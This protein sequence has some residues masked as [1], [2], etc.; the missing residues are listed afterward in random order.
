[1]LLNPFNYTSSP[2]IIFHD[3]YS[4]GKIESL[5]RRFPDFTLCSELSRRELNT[6]LKADTIK[7]DTTTPNH[8]GPIYVPAWYF[9]FDCYRKTI[10][11]N[12]ID[13][14]ELNKYINKTKTT[15]Q[16]YALSNI[17][18][19][20]E[21]KYTNDIVYTDSAYRNVIYKLVDTFKL[22]WE[23]DHERILNNDMEYVQK[24]IAGVNHNLLQRFGNI[25]EA[26]NEI[27][28]A[29][30]IFN[31][32]RNHLKDDTNNPNLADFFMYFY[33]QYFAEQRANYVFEQQ[34]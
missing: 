4:A 11:A 12:K 24:T 9:A 2:I 20:L 25:N 29:F 32:R 22:L 33:L 14:E 16:T 26:F 23:L 28:P 31:V 18:R 30:S 17:R 21:Y 27:R 19:Y 6:K 34:I 5:L 7:Y 15:K 3:N 1:M 8:R 10:S 13:N